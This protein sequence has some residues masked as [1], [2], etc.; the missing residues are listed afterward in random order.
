MSLLKKFPGWSKRQIK[1][2]DF[3][4]KSPLLSRL[5]VY[6]SMTILIL[7]VAG[8]ITATIFLFVLAKDLP[9]PR[10][11]A[12]I[13]IAESTH[14]YDR[15]G[16]LLYE[17]HGDERRTIVPLRDISQHIVDAT[18]AIED[19]E[20]YL[21]SGFDWKGILRAA[22]YDAWSKITREP[23]LQGG[24]TITQ[25]FVKNTFLTRERT[26]IRKLK[27]LIL[28]LQLEKN[29]TKDEI[30]ALYLNQIS[31]GANIHGV[32][33]ASQAFFNKDAK[34]VTLAE[35]ATLAAIPK[36]PTYYSPYGPNSSELMTRKNYVLS[37]MV[38]VKKITKV[39]M[40]ETKQEELSFQPYREDIKAP[41]FIFYIR[42][43]LEERFGK[44]FV[45]HGGLRVTTSLSGQLQE[46]AEEK[47]KEGVENNRKLWDATNAG[48]VAI[49]P[50]NGEVLAMVGS[51]DYFDQKY[52]GQVNVTLA[53]RQPGSAFKPFVYATGFMEGY[54]PA[55]VV[56]DV[57]T[58]F[59][60]TDEPYAPVN[61]TETFKGPVSLRSALAESINIPAV[62]ILHLAGV[63]DV[64]NLVAKLGIT[65]LNDPGR[66]GLSLVLGGGEVRLL[67]MVGAYGVFATGGTFHEINPFISIEDK[68]GNSIYQRVY[69]DD[70]K[71]VLPDQIAYLIN[72]ILS[73]NQARTPVFGWNNFLYLKDHKVAAKTGTTNGF[74]DAWTI[75]YT[76][77][78]VAGVWV[79][80]NDNTAMKEKSAGGAIAAPIWNKFM[81]AALKN[82][83]N[84]DFARPENIVTK[85]VSTLDGLLP[86]T[87][88]PDSRRRNEIFAADYNVPLQV[89]TA[90]QTA[91]VCTPTGKLANKYCPD[92]LRRTLIYLELHSLMPHR[93]QWEQPVQDWLK[94]NQ[95][96]K[97]DEFGGNFEIVSN[98]DAIPT[99]VDTTFTAETAKTIPGIQILNPL[100]GSTVH[101]GTSRVDFDT[102]TPNGFE[103]VKFFFGPAF[104]GVIND[105]D[106]KEFELEITAGFEPGNY[107]LKAVVID[108]LG[109]Q[110]KTS[111]DLLLVEEESSSISPASPDDNIDELNNDD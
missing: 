59:S 28:A 93:F 56:F 33:A 75:G 90:I 100:S 16:K 66:Y 109:L 4:P 74:R 37:R 45:S 52:D 85:T 3:H 96:L 97:E 48:L 55:T 27:E 64:L 24:S 18:L 13:N 2:P 105:P 80:N 84:E 39:E 17:I 65:T 68:S 51:Y 63:N 98:K 47:I 44:E 53:K 30:L 106:Q 20:F 34:D 49:N 7:V 108:K 72:D 91:T 15:D 41:H 8:A 60:A 9:T 89:S 26:V 12:N 21:H 79:G 73:D 71:K 29:F 58:D 111:I 92:H 87:Y 78:L 23:R 54:S 5:F 76:P 31:Y 43:L 95:L 81:N 10:D 36:A 40:E 32:Q 50:K 86:N 22:F 57:L 99:E 83:P 6:S 62:K 82:E 38:E 11:L 69:D 61:Y 103:R 101:F 107:Q 104:K 35:A 1:G 42:Q 70:G 25:Q 77:S 110:N 94:E 19:D 14:I 46:I 88:T 102:V 67:E